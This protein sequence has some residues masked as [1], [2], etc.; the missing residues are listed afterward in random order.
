M[1][2]DGA[3]PSL[4][5]TGHTATITLQCPRVANRLGPEDLQILADHLQAVNASDARVLVLRSS[6]KY[7]CSG[8][9]IGKL[10]AGERG[11]G[12]EGLVNALED[13]R[14]VTI[15]AIQ[16]GVFGGGT[17]LALACDFR[18]GA[19]PTEMFMPAARLGL[20]FYE[21]GM[22]RYV[23]RLGLNQAKRLFLTA[24]RL[25]ATEMLE[26]GFLTELLAD[27]DAVRERVRSLSE[28]IAGLAPLAVQGMKRH[29]NAIGRGALDSAALA[30]DLL[31]SAQSEDIRE[32]ARAWAEKR[33]PIFVG[34]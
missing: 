10:A 28:T 6:G 4:E 1:T 9:D 30:S 25:N 5:L 13:C 8:F 26:I 17:D 31:R 22:L 20:H 24:E 3:I 32:G 33:M 27:E 34:S 19:L 29:L 11:M 21:R 23:S 18:V 14:P 7:F 12:F 16:G 15:A 2:T